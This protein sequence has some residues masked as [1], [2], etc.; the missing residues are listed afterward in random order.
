MSK[1]PF[2]P[3]ATDALISDTTHLTTEEF[4]AYVLLM[5]A[6]WRMNGAMLPADDSK[7]SRI[8]RMG[9]RKWHI[10]RPQ[11][12]ELFDVTTNG[13]SQKR[14]LKD[15][16]AVAGR[17]EINRKNG[18]RGGK[19]KSLKTINQDVA[20]ATN[21]L[22]VSLEQKGDFAT[23][24]H[25]HNH[26]VVVTRGAAA[27]QNDSKT[28]SEI[29]RLNR[30]LGFDPND[31]NSHSANIRSLI[32]LKAEGCDFERHIRR[33]AEKCVGKANRLAYIAPVARQLRDSDKT[34]TA[35]GPA[36]VQFDPT[37]AKGWAGRIRVWNERRKWIAKWG[38]DPDQ[39]GCKIPA[40]LRSTITAL[41]V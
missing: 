36:V 4:G 7:L 11:I 22:D 28:S 9:V 37:D 19:S 29:D 41:T 24:N 13:W 25:N 39:P 20:N 2:W 26:K 32:D 34:I 8:A 18:S 5:I 6:Q 33:A 14:V 17:L 35:T 31:W 27:D 15:Y 23:S 21:S 12:A 1:A 38:P 30:I 10:I 40:E 3:V 16:L